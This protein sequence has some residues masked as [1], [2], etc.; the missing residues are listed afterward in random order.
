MTDA[1]ATTEKPA[2]KTLTEKAGQ[3]FWR[4]IGAAFME[5][6]VNP[7]TGERHL[8][9]GL[10]RIMALA[11]FVAL[12]IMWL[13]RPEMLN[14]VGTV[15]DPVPNSMLCTFWGLLGLKGV[16]VISNSIKKEGN[17]DV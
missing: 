10:T 4:W 2:T 17:A 14:D 16:N 6:K 13:T 7:R 12:M 15:T 8:A 11:M 3:Q 5:A 9:V 1:T